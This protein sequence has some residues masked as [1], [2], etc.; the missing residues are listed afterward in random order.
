MLIFELFRLPNLNFLT[1]KYLNISLILTLPDCSPLLFGV[2]FNISLI[3][4]PF[5][6]QK[7]MSTIDDLFRTSITIFVKLVARALYGL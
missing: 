5:Q 2:C 4:E 1:I 7:I 3:V 6:T